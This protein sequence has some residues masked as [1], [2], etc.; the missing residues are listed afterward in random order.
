MGGLIRHAP[1]GTLGT[2]MKNVETVEDLKAVTRWTK[3]APNEAVTALHVGGP[4]ALAWMESA[5][6]ESD[7]ALGKVLRKGAKA[8]SVHRTKI[9]LAKFLWRGRLKEIEP[10][11][12]DWLTGN[13]IA[14]AITLALCLLGT[15]AAAMFGWSAWT[16]FVRVFQGN[17]RPAKSSAP[18]VA[19]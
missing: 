14:R 17:L 15:G 16:G 1:A 7:K 11:I 4:E 10:G 6:V 3:A 5:A 12:V 8:L 19:N 9:R 13:A 2:A 18:P